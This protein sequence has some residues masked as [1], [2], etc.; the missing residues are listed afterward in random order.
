MMNVNYNMF[1]QVSYIEHIIKKRETLTADL[2]IH[3]AINGINNKL[4]FKIKEGYK[5]EL[6]TPETMNL[7]RSKNQLIYETKKQRK[8][9]KF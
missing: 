4:A 9:T 2:P 8:R 7:F 5:L 6:Q 3:I 1:L